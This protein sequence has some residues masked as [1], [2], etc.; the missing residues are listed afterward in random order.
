M[1]SCN[2]KYLDSATVHY[3]ELR[4]PGTSTFDMEKIQAMIRERILFPQVVVEDDRR[5]LLSSI[6]QVK[7]LIPSFRTFFEN[8]KFM[9]P[10]SLILKALL[11][12]SEKRSLWRGFQANFWRPENIKVQYCENKLATFQRGNLQLVPAYQDCPEN[13]EKRLGYLQLW[14]FCFRHFPQM[15][16]LTPRLASRREKATIEQNYALWPALGALAC[17]LGFRTD[18][19][20]LYAKKDPDVEQAAQF[21]S[22]SRPGSIDQVNYEKCLQNIVCEMKGLSGI[23]EQTGFCKFTRSTRYSLD[24]R[25]GRP[26]NDD[27]T[28]DKNFLFAPSLVHE[29]LPDGEERD[30]TSLYVKRDLIQ[31]FFGDVSD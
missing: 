7:C 31:A 6:S 15:T 19:A 24:R 25:C 1:G 2:R 8:Q 14:L 28:N 29:P 30:I 21:L 23:T 13:Y 18:V 3:L 11:G 17:K 9:E 10:C 22:S 5:A 16:P 27:H 26:Y 4:S 12:P 20:E